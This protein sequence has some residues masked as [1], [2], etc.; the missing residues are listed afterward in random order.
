MTDTKKPA[1]T[2]TTT[3]PADG[4]DTEA[5]GWTAE[6]KAAMQE[7]ARELKAAAK[8]GA[9]AADGEKDLLAKIAEMPEAD[10][11]IAERIH[12]V[13]SA[14]APDFLPRTYY[15]M[16]AWGRDGKVFCFFQPKEKFKARYATI[17][18]EDKA[19]L[20]DG[21]IW[22][23]A[24]ARDEVHRR[25]RGVA[26]RPRE[27]GRRLIDRHGPIRAS[28]GGGAEGERAAASMDR[29]RTGQAAASSSA[30]GSSS[31]SVS[32]GI[33]SLGGASP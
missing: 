15:G 2:A 10:R 24:F 13:V 23:T 29:M 7:H 1:K 33:G 4:R 26:G 21:A 19:N 5:V 18:F 25:R 17:G 9:K 20:D 30:S 3:K 27:E 16:P 11:V 32:A 14:N 22:P 28:E 31:I 6:E 8:K 12:K